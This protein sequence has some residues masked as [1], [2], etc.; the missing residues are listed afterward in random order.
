MINDLIFVSR[1]THKLTEAQEILRIPLTLKSLDDLNWNF[2]LPET[3]GTIRGNS[4]QK[5]QTFYKQSGINC[6]SDDTGLEVE[7]LNGQPGVDTAHY[8]GTRDAQ[9]NMN[10]LLHELGKTENRK[11]RFVTV[12]TLIWE[13]SEYIFEGEVMGRIAYQ[14]S[15]AGGFGYDPIFIPLGYDKTFA[16]LDA[17]V[18]NKISHRAQAI[19]LLAA[20]FK[21]IF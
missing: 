1:N 17:T 18:K 20:H 12:I 7:A 16:E 14:I 9:S 11:A 15:G 2:E 10:K 21:N 6:F 8:S 4:I 13:G 3:S 19:N 5:A